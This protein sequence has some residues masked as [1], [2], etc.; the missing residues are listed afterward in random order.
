MGNF[1]GQVVRGSATA[2][3]GIGSQL[4]GAPWWASAGLL[5]M[6]L[7]FASR[8]VRFVVVAVTLLALGATKQEAR[9]R[10]MRIAYYPSSPDPT[11]GGF[12]PGGITGTA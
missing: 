3:V 4:A 12:S 9:D 7:L 10:G 2:G 1:G 6:V 8:P 11:L 5:V